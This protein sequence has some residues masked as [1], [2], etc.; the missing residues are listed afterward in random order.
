MK[1]KVLLTT[2][3]IILGLIGLALSFI[4]AEILTFLDV[5]NSLTIII[6]MQILGALYLGFAM[7]NWMAKDALFGGIYNKPMTIGNLMHFSAGALALI[8]A[9][10]RSEQFL[11]SMIVLTIIYSIFALCFAY[12]FFNNPKSVSK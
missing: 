1:T 8:K 3:S 11:E 10:I 5:E 12:V 2:S 4:P 7:M 6:F 9:I